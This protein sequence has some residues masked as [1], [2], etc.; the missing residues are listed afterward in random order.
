M[1]DVIPVVFK[2]IHARSRCPVGDIGNPSMPLPS[3]KRTKSGG[4]QSSTEMPLL[5]TILYKLYK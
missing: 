4:N 5:A 3:E 2:D 1:L